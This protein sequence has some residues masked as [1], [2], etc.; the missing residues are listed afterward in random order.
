MKV[1]F[2]VLQNLKIVM[3]SSREDLGTNVRKQVLLIYSYFAITAVWWV[4]REAENKS[5]SASLSLVQNI[6]LFIFQPNKPGRWI[7]FMT[8]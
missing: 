2:N 1:I 4:F 8:K 7:K 3:S 5:N 6:I